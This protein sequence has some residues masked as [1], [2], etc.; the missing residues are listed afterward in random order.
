MNE[1]L[2]HY[3]WWLL[4]LAL[5]GVEMIAPGYFML[6]IGIA[7]AAMGVV[8]WLAPA[9]PALAQAVLF[10]LFG[11]ASCLVYWWFIRPLAEQRDD[12][13]LL[14]RRGERMIGRHVIVSEAFINGRGK[15]KVG[16]GEWL[17]EGSEDVAAGTKVEVVA[18]RGTTLVVR[19]VDAPH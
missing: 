5:V 1:F 9:L 10:A 15:V 8:T 19:A 2:G 14:N 4:A 7:A 17:G 6:W 13:P 11:V 18:L 16:D 12:Q 3:G